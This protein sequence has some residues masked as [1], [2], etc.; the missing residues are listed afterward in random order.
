MIAPLPA[1]LPV[2]HRLR[3]LA[4]TAGL[5]AVLGGPL[6]HG[7]RIELDVAGEDVRDRD[8]SARWRG[9]VLVEE[10]PAAL[11]PSQRGPL[12]DAARRLAAAAALPAVRLDIV[13][14]ED[15]PVLV[16]ATPLAALPA[17]ADGVRLTA[18]LTA[19]EPALGG[20]ARGTVTALALPPGATSALTLGATVDLAAGAPLATVGAVGADRA[21]ALAALRAALDA[22]RIDGIPSDLA[23]LRQAVASPSFAE[24]LASAR[25]LDGLPY[26]PPAL[27]VMTP[28]THTTVQDFP[29]RLGY[30]AVGVPP[31]GP[32]DDLAFRLANR[33]VGNG[34][35]TAALEFTLVG[36]TLRFLGDAIIAIAGA[37]YAPTLDGQPIPTWTA[38]AV[39]AGAVLRLG[40]PTGGGCRATLAVRGGIAVPEYL[41]SRSTFDLGGFGGH[42]GRPLQTG[43]VVPLAR[44]VPAAELAQCPQAAP[45]RPEYARTWEIGVLEGPHAAPDFLTPADLRE[46]YATA[47]TVHH[48]SNRTGV[49]LIGPKPRW[50]RPDGGDA[51]L[52]PSNI[53][54]NAYAVG[55]IDFTGDMPIL[56]GPDGPSCGGFVCPAV[57]VEAE[58]WKLGQ[59]RP[60]DKV[61]FVRIN[62][63]EAERRRTVQE[64]WIATLRRPPLPHCVGGDP[65]PAVIARLPARGA[66]PELRIRRSGDA[67][68]LAEWG[69]PQLDLALRLRAHRVETALAARALDGLIDLTPGIRSLQV[70]VDPARLPLDRLVDTLAALDEA[71]P[72]DDDTEVASRTVHLPLAWDDPDTRK[73]I[74]LYQRS[75]RPDAPWCPSNLEFIRRINGLGSIDDV[76]RVLFDAEYLVMGL[77]DVYLGAPVATPLDPR[78]R[79]V[80]TKYN[81]ARTWT[82]ENAVGIGGAYLCVYGMEG[83]GG[84][85]FVGRTVPVW[86]TWRQTTAFT[87]PWLLRCFDRIRFHP[88]PYDELM[89]LRAAA[90]DG[91]WSPR[92][93]EGVFRW[94]DHQRFLA[95]HADGIAA[96]RATQQAAFAAERARW[97]TAR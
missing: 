92:I 31:S 81:P 12:H 27:A 61:R 86:N 66:K 65:G 46:L 95:A 80:T 44:P 75:V 52:H 47:Y 49:R 97:G 17:A 76:Q 48:N 78:H 90:R 20:P 39:P 41:G 84:Y 42:A 71:L 29:G 89:R 50:A 5:R 88:V 24:G 69:P 9:R 56:L 18:L 63:A 30:W 53:H 36:P 25:T 2:R 58:R 40:P 33:L 32:M 59:L 91:T 22:L 72:A 85:Q 8:T 96:F 4:E 79:L 51:G 16:A 11:T 68:V 74:A 64:R 37:A 83:P 54:D 6:P 3:Q 28:G 7:R 70:H 77:G 13:L 73:A 57:V 82:P 87:R 23:L 1:V 34:P 19:G 35:G 14:A 93:E 55:A 43:D 94:R 10:E 21:S 15:G 45:D 62:P 60:G 38:V 26:A 67:Y